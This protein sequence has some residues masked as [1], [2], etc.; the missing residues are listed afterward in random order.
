MAIRNRFIQV[1][2]TDMMGIVHHSNYLRLCE[3]ARVQW[4]VSQNILGV[5]K[6]DVFS[7]TVV[8]A[9]VFYKK[10]LKYAD[11]AS[12]D[13]QIKVEG[14]RLFIEYK[15][16]NGENELCALAET[17]HCSM[18]QNFKPTRLNSELVKKVK[19]SPWKETWL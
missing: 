5:T 16:L 17:I 3:E 18:D 19:E 1:Y 6:E 2:E 14:A 10:S 11:Y 15:I 13:L 4:F 12:V 9:Q 8:T 7:L